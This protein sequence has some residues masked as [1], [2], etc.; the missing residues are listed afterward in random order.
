MN[1]IGFSFI[2]SRKRLS[3]SFSF[4]LISLLTISLNF[5]TVLGPFLW[6]LP[7]LV[8]F[9]CYFLILC[10]L[11][12]YPIV[13]VI[14]SVAPLAVSTAIHD[15]ILLWGPPVDRSIDLVH[16]IIA[17]TAVIVVVSTTRQAKAD[18]KS[19]ELRTRE[20]ERA[21]RV[22]HP[23]GQKTQAPGSTMVGFIFHTTFGTVMGLSS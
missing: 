22:I 4:S 1:D 9:L 23:E 5:F 14:F 7:F 6:P 21:Q 12:C 10:W 20:R 11:C 15:G 2:L 13:L 18:G 17:T 3:F 19:T 16:I 8:L